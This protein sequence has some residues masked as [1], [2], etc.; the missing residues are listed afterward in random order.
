MVGK[1]KR[2]I[3]TKSLSGVFIYPILY[4]YTNISNR[5]IA[6][7]TERLDK[8]VSIGPSLFERSENGM[9]VLA[10]STDEKCIN[11]EK[12]T[13]IEACVQFFFSGVVSIYRTISC[14]L[15]TSEE[16]MF[17]NNASRFKRLIV[18]PGYMC[19]RLYERCN[20]IKVGADIIYWL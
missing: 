6:I 18:P 17:L 11:C 4:F 16:D 19:K 20:L 7:A 14:Y 8:T 13:F 12:I 5:L 3:F 10:S 9:F 15:A 1:P 2:D